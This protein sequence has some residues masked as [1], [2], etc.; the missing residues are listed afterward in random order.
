M[1]MKISETLLGRKPVDVWTS[2]S[3]QPEPFGACGQTMDNA[4]ALPTVSPHSLASRPQIHRFSNSKFYFL[5]TGILCLFF[6]LTKNSFRNKGKLK[7]KGLTVLGIA[8]DLSK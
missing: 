3:D 7:D 6:N 4:T 2:P 5:K 1:M 8:R